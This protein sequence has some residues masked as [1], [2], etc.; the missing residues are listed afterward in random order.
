MKT[1]ILDRGKTGLFALVDDK[2][3]EYLNQFRW[4]S[5][6]AHKTNNLFYA[7]RTL[8]ASESKKKKGIMMHRQI[9]E[10]TDSKIKV[11]HKDRNGLNNQRNNIRICTL[12]QNNANRAPLP[13]KTSKY[14]GVCFVASRNTWIAST[15]YKNKSIRIGQFDNEIDAALAY[16]AKAKEIHG[17]FANLNVI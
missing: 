12:S 15:S 6:K 9:L 3:Y 4:R 17:E 16:N 7:T 2:D 10:L 11:D 14:L 8:L 5:K 1:I 13:N